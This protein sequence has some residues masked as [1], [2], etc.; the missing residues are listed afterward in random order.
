MLL[1]LLLPLLVLTTSP[2]V[3]A[4]AR[5]DEE[6]AGRATGGDAMP[7]WLARLA[8]G[9]PAVLSGTVAGGVAGAAIPLV[10]AMVLMTPIVLIGLSAAQNPEGFGAIIGL[11]TFLVG[12]MVVV[13]VTLVQ[14]PFWDAVLFTL[15]AGVV[16]TVAELRNPRPS[17]ASRALRVA[18]AW[19]AALM[20]ALPGLLI[21]TVLLAAAAVAVPVL[22]FLTNNIGVAVLPEWVPPGVILAGVVGAG[23]ALALHAALALALRPLIFTALRRWAASADNRT[24]RER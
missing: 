19:A 10:E 14:V 15:G 1:H 7:R 5:D 12:A 17:L 21:A 11:L 2:D 23:L 8:E 22:F 3:D 18:G 16:A 13:P 4:A 24:P 6:L 9:A 20:G